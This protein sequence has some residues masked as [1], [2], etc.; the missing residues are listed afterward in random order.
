MNSHK[1]V[2]IFSGGVQNWHETGLGDFLIEMI[3][4]GLSDYGRSEYRVLIRFTSIWL[5]MG[6]L[7]R[8]LATQNL[9]HW[10]ATAYGLQLSASNLF[11]FISITRDARLAAIKALYG[12]V[13]QIPSF[14]YW[15]SGAQGLTTTILLFLFG[16]CLRNKFRL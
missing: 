14:V 15:L 8:D 5:L 6:T 7:F 13:D 10:S 9:S 11:P 1:Q 3:Y 4:K 12:P 2:R 16:L